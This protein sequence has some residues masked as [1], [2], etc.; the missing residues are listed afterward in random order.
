LTADLDPY[1]TRRVPELSGGRQ[2]SVVYKP[3]NVKHVR[4]AVLR[5]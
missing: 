5:R 1:L 2:T 3:I 4:L